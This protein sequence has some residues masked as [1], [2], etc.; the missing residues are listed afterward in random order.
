MQHF[1]SSISVLLPL[2]FGFCIRLPRRYL[3][4]I[5]QS[6][7]FFV[8]FI[9]FLI[10][11]SLAKLDNLSEQF[12]F[13]IGAALLLFVCTLAMNVLCLVWFDRR[14]P[15]SLFKRPDD[16]SKH[17]IHIMTSVRQLGCVFIG[18]ILGKI[19]PAAWLPA[20]SASSYALLL[21]LLL[22]GIQLRSSGISLRR[23]LINR[24][25]VQISGIFIGSCLV[26]GAVFSLLL[27]H[28]SLSQGLA[29][30]S[31]YGWYT[32]S[33]IVMHEAY[34]PVWGSIA[35]FNDLARELFA[36]MIIPK[37]MLRYPSAAVGVGGGTSI[38]FTLPILQA[39]GGVDIVPLAISFGFICNVM[40]P[41]LMALFSIMNF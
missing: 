31:G 39:S 32:L 14:H 27:P 8:Y 16:V 9:L 38:D 4:W 12:G 26:G 33:S 3:T 10:G 2:F 41:I 36:M 29:M 30:S 20:H 35:L 23:V 25:G 11:L 40:A 19:V 34:G 28:V 18:V 15:W 7:V 13:I 22:V 6:L 21:L 5:E 24:R 1:I 17:A 37:L